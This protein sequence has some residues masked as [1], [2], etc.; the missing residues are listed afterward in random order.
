[1]LFRATQINAD[2]F[3]IGKLGDARILLFER[4]SSGLRNFGD[5]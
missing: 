1:M 4:P 2:N 5:K 3:K